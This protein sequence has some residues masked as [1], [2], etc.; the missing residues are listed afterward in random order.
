LEISQRFAF[1]VHLLIKYFRTTETRIISCLKEK[2]N[3]EPNWNFW[4]YLIGPDGNVLNAWGPRV[5]LQKV[6]QAVKEEVEKLNGE[7]IKDEL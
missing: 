3:K 4:K 6:Y 1:S 5:N 7:E 2:S